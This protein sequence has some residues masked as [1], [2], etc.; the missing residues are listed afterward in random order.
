MENGFQGHTG[1]QVPVMTDEFVKSVSD[2][3]IELFEGIT[4]EKFVKADVTA[5]LKRVEQNIMNFLTT[6]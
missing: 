4:G 5:V 3:Y 2:R 1:Q 6:L